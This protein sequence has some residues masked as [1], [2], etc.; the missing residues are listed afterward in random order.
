MKVLSLAAG[1]LL[2]AGCA[3]NNGYYNNGAHDSYNQ[4]SQSLDDIHNAAQK[5]KDAKNEYK[6]YD[7]EGDDYFENKA[8]ER[9]LQRHYEIKNKGQR[10]KQDWNDIF[11]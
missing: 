2:L 7:N 6:R 9:L 10:L 3:N 11:D 8:K 1:I 4:V 5:I